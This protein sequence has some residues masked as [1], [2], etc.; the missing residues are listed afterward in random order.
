M[1]TERN[2][3]YVDVPAQFKPIINTVYPPNNQ[4][5]YERWFSLRYEGAE[6]ERVYLPILFCGYQVNHNYGKDERA[7][8]RLQQFVDSLPEDE[9]YFCLS[10][11]DDSVGVDFKGKDVLIFDMSKT[12]GNRY[13]LPLIG[14]NHPFAF[15]FEKKQYFANFIGNPTHPIRQHAKELIGKEGYYVSFKHHDIREYCKIISQSTFTLCYRGYGL[16]SFRIKE[17][18]QLGSIPVYISDEFIEA[19]NIP[20]DTYGVKITEADLPNMHDILTDVLLNE[21]SDKPK[22]TDMDKL[23]FSYEGCYQ[24]IIQH[25][26]T[27]A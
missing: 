9:K 11:Y 5:E 23:G 15:K 1:N 18:L 22:E 14:E 24:K 2:I 12:G 27:G 3:R 16:N 10:Q 25:L 20:I 13:P 8:M 4:V 19:H 21:L 7:M 6:T 26:E 17:A